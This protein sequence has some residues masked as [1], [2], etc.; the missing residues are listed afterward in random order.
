M[1]LTR[2]VAIS[3]TGIAMRTNKMSLIGVPAIAGL[4]RAA[5]S[6]A[7]RLFG[8]AENKEKFATQVMHRVN[9]CLKTAKTS[10]GAIDPWLR[11]A[12]RNAKQRWGEKPA[13][14]RG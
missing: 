8:Y 1:A 9:V 13:S 12:I 11:H 3:G 4:G 6:A 7:A 14:P 2:T 5:E 10:S